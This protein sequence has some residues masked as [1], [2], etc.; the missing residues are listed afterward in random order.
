MVRADGEREVTIQKR[1]RSTDPTVRLAACTE[2]AD[3]IE[4]LNK[5]FD[6][7]YSLWRNEAIENCKDEKSL[8][9]IFLK[10]LP[11]ESLDSDVHGRSS[12][13]EISL[14]LMHFIKNLAIEKK[15]LLKNLAHAQRRNK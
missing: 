10:V 3:E 6:Q 1:L 11:G 14:K 12:I 15:D 5:K 4:C 2:A 9:D 13:A 7:I 8:R